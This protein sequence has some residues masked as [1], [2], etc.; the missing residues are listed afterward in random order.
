MRQALI[1]EG[2]ICALI[3]VDFVGVFYSLF[4]FVCFVVVVV[5]LLLLLHHLSRLFQ[6]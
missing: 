4:Y 5:V 2:S 6:N 3:L 1:N